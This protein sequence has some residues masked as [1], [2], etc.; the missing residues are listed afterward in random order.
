MTA[1]DPTIYSVLRTLVDHSTLGMLDR[2]KLHRNID[3]VDPD[4]TPAPEVKEPETP[5]QELTRLRQEAADRRVA[6]EAE[7]QVATS[8][9]STGFR[10]PDGLV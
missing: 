5:E 4:A 6:D 7:R 10:V 1:N 9:P 3:V 8:D 2:L